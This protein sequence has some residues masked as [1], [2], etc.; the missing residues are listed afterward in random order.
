[1]AASDSFNLFLNQIGSE[2]QNFTNHVKGILALVGAWYTLRLT[3]NLGSS[4]Y[5]LVKNSKS[6]WK[7]TNFVKK[8]GSWAII[9][10]IAFYS[11]FVYCK[12]IINRLKPSI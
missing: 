7:N 2:L 4:T 8:Y 6:I 12:T 3:I 9:T 10:G 11:S 5:K 1:M